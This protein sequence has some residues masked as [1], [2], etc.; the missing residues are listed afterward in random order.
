MN[1]HL[2]TYTLLGV[3]SL[4]Y[5][6]DSPAQSSSVRNLDNSTP[7]RLDINSS[8]GDINSSVRVTTTPVMVSGMIGGVPI[9]EVYEV[10]VPVGAPPPQLSPGQ[11]V[12]GH[13]F[14][15]DTGP[16]GALIRPANVA[17]QPPRSMGPAVTLSDSAIAHS[18][19]NATAAIE[20]ARSALAPGAGIKGDSTRA[21]LFI[22]RAMLELQQANQRISALEAAQSQAL[23]NSLSE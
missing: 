8:A 17:A 2:K 16:G 22:D 13:N 11:S 14:I 9:S 1:T 5:A 18:V 4:V 20:K 6:S 15:Y 3:L 7:R 19:S 23:A 10:T 12:V 21:L